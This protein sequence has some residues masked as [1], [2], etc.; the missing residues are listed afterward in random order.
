M[1]K[2]KIITLKK[3]QSLV[4]VVMAVG[5]ISLILVGLVSAISFSLSNTQYARNKAL[6][7]KYSQE[8]LEWFRSE[9]DTLGWAAFVSY[10][11][12][13]TC[14][15][16]NY[17]QNQN[18]FSWSVPGTCTGVIVDNLNIFK[19]NTYLQTESPD[20]VK[21]SVTTQWSQ[22]S[23]DPSVVL[24]TY[25]TNYRG[26]S[27]VTPINCDFPATPAPVSTPLPSPPPT[28]LPS[29]SPDLSPVDILIQTVS[30][31]QHD[32]RVVV[33]NE[34]STAVAP[35]SQLQTTIASTTYTSSVDPLGIGVSVQVFVVSLATL[36]CQVTA[37]VDP[38]NTVV[39]ANESNNTRTE[40]FNCPSPTPTPVPSPLPDLRPALIFFYD[41]FGQHNLYVTVNNESSVDAPSTPLR[42]TLDG[43]APYEVTVGY[44]PAG[45]SD[46]PKITTV[47]VEPCQVTA[48]ADP[49]NV[50]AEA[51]EANNTLTQYF[52]CS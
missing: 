27:G 34:S 39:E 35:A 18:T 12:T 9:R 2:K 50:L 37:T 51:N 42:V 25:L 5:I 8:A 38:A 4:E 11:P 40:N 30:P 45:T 23:R 43:G 29:P 41:V 52:N 7:T 24:S 26:T 31:S 6:A 46:S 44:L 14:N 48:V 47:T 22:G 10:A 19:R 28:P 33:R 49:G 20:R 1:K 21:V 13:V 15:K 36:P 32:V 17:C 3:G 16:N